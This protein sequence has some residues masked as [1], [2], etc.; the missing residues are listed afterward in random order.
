MFRKC[1]YS[2]GFNV[3][4]FLCDKFNSLYNCSAYKSDVQ[5]PSSRAAE[6][7]KNLILFNDLS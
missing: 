5:L 2:R 6:F 1:G 3:D 4:R 7:Q